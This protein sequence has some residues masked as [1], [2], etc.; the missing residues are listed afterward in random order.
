MALMGLHLAE[1]GVHEFASASVQHD[2]SELG[3]QSGYPAM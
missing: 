3:F 1:H 2:V